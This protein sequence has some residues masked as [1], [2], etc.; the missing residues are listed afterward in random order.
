MEKYVQFRVTVKDSPRQVGGRTK[1]YFT[2][3]GMRN[4]VARA[5]CRHVEVQGC[6]R[7]ESVAGGF[8]WEPVAL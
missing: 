8:N 3:R 5:A 7:D 6:Y 4:A 2:E 1:V